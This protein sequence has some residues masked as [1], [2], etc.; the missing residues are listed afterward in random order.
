M[1][2]LPG[3]KASMLA[4]LVA[5]V[6]LSGSVVAFHVYLAG[7]EHSDGLVGGIAALWVFGGVF[8]FGALPGYLSV[9]YR[10][11]SPAALASGVYVLVLYESV[12]HVL[13]REQSAG[14]GLVTTLFD[15]FL[16]FWFV[17]LAGAL[18][19]G[20]IEYAIRYDDPLSSKE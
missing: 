14:A 20:A 4:G 19:V 7:F 5:G 16:L 15:L 3:R 2:G 6:L 18:V 8:L 13:D 17:P 9:R 10:L 12:P 1:G 11:F